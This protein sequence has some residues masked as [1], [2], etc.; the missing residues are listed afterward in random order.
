MA[1][2]GHLHGHRLPNDADL[3][4]LIGN[5]GNETRK[6]PILEVILKR[7]EQPDEVRAGQ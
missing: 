1:S 2:G 5:E 7:F 4:G 3:S 6:K